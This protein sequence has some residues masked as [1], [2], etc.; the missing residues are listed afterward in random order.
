MPDDRPCVVK[1][2]VAKYRNLSL[3]VCFRLWQAAHAH[4]VPRSASIQKVALRTGSRIV[5]LNSRR[6]KGWSGFS[7]PL[8]RQFFFHQILEKTTAPKV[9]SFPPNS[10][11]SSGGSLVN[12]RRKKKKM[13]WHR[14]ALKKENWSPNLAS[15]HFF[16]ASAKKKKIKVQ[17][18]A[19]LTLLVNQEIKKIKNKKKKMKVQ[20]LAQL[21]FLV[22]WQWKKKKAELAWKRCEK[23]QNRIGMEMLAW[24]QPGNKD[25]II[26]C[27]APRPT[28]R[29][30]NNQLLIFACFAFRIKVEYWTERLTGLHTFKRSGHRCA[31]AH[32]RTLWLFYNL[33]REKRKLQCSAHFTE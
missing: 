26:V 11:Q 8:T 12:Q 5:N 7:H 22:T 33:H 32:F 6:N 15:V 30:D 13:N 1:P 19:Q 20:I 29:R 14:L 28:A 25:S 3:S 18:L 10:K 31:L 21:T 16:D 27:G 17:I 23:K 24:K 9:P 4:I 2:M